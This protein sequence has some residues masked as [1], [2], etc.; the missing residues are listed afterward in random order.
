MVKEFGTN[1]KVAMHKLVYEMHSFFESSG[2]EYAI[3]GG[4]ALDM[5]AGKT[6]RTHGDFDVLIFSEDKQRIIKFM[7]DNNWLV[8]GR[9][10]EDG[11]PITQHLFYKID[12]IANNY[13]DDCKNIWAVKADCL[14][15]V[16][17]KIDRIPGEVYT[18]QS[19]KWLVQDKLEFIELEFD[20]RDDSNYIARE[21]PKIARVLD[22]AILHRDGIPYLAPEIILFY[23]SDKFSVENAYAKPKT[24]SDFKTIMPMLPTESKQWLLDA[25]AKTY[26]D[27]YVWLDELL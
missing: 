17:D 13:W 14:P 18:Y 22:K 6:L 27:G 1:V 16:L 11:K 24:E 23:K 26:P 4:Y 8:F 19:R 5:F 2:V 20:A 21:D 25:I 7:M 15:A 9:F 10:M 12:D 3:C